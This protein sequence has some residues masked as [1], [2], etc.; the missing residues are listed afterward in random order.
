MNSSHN[1]PAAPVLRRLRRLGSV[2]GLLTLSA[3]TVGT[4]GC[5][6]GSLLST[7]D[8]IRIGR[9]ASEEIEKKYHVDTTS[10][11]AERVRRIGERLVIHTDQ[12][13]GVPYSFKVLDMKDVNAVSLPGGP[14]YVFRGLLDLVGD[15]DDAL[16]T[17]IAHEIGHV[18]GRHIAKQYTKQ[19][20]A[21]LLLTV[22]LQGKGALAQNVAGLGLELMSYKFSR[23]DEYDAD[24]RGLSYAYKAGFDPQGLP[25]FFQ[26]LQA[27]EKRGGPPEFL[28]DHPVTGARIDRAKKI[29]ETQ[30]YKFGQ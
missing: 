16:A 29:I 28:R 5:G 24:K 1:A 15:D 10:T 17:V 7:K 4:T 14:I 8:E 27:M 13:A 12:R 11:D 22:L 20:Q 26:K 18:N 6:K 21:Q 3:M 23:D 25:R 19:V 30:E 2:L 9:Q